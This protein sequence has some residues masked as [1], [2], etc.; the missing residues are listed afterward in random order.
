M[1]CLV[2]VSLRSAVGLTVLLRADSTSVEGCLLMLFPGSDDLESLVM[3][4]SCV[5]QM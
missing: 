3:Y 5:S 1:F 4:G 2:L